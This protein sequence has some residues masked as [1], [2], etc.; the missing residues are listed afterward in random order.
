[1]WTGEFGGVTDIDIAF[2][3]DDHFAVDFVDDIVN[4]LPEHIRHGRDKRLLHGEGICE[5]LK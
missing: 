2:L 3:D 5:Q 1:V 4:L